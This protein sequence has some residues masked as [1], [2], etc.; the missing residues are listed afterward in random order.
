MG[1]IG[2][3]YAAATY[4]QSPGAAGG[5]AAF[6]RNSA[7]GPNSN[8]PLT[9]NLATNVVWTLIAS[10]EA[11]GPNVPI[12]PQATG[13]VIVEVVVNASNSDTAAHT[14]NVAVAVGGTPVGPESIVELGPTGT[15]ASQVAIPVQVPISDLPIGDTSEITVQVTASAANVITL[16]ISRSSISVREVGVATG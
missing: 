13:N 16:P 8:Q 7:V 12:T 6:A 11:A 2:R 1:R 9:T 15:A 10:T 5:T 14:L 3:K 4:P